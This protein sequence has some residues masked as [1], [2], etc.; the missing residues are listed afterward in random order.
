MP[1]TNVT[2]AVRSVRELDGE[3]ESCDTAAEG[4]LRREGEKL[5]LT[6]FADGGRAVLT[7]RP[8]CVVLERT[9]EIASKM[10]FRPGRRCLSDY[11]TPYGAMPM[12]V[13]T[14]RL[15]HR[16]T[17]EGG[18]LVLEYELELGGDSLGSHTVRI[19]AHTKE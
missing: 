9:G 4:V 3:K 13:T 18:E 11:V 14:R 16:L 1:E 8:E 15:E 6:Y 19:T 7:A 5:T 12:A 17:G 2:V 10:V